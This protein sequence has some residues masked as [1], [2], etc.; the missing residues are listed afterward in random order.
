MNRLQKNKKKVH[1]F[2]GPFGVYLR[3]SYF[4]V[5]NSL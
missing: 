4:L 5:S 2:V 3:N 1:F